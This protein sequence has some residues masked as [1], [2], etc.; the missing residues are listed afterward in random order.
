MGNVIN[1]PK[2]LTF[3]YSF[4]HSFICSFVYLLILSVYS[5]AFIYLFFTDYLF[6]HLFIDVVNVL[7]LTKLSD[8]LNTSSESLIS[9]HSL[10]GHGYRFW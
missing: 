1:T 9:T 6:V 2:T 7:L 3:T 8:Q 5:F 4:I 10:L